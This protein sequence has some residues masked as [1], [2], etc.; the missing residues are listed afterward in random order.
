MRF[1]ISHGFFSRAAVF[2]FFAAFSCSLWAQTGAR[3]ADWY[4]GKPIRNVVFL[5]LKHVKQ[6]ELDGITEPYIGK[7]LTDAALAELLGRLYELEYFD[8]ISPETIPSG[9]GG[10]EAVLRFT[11]KERPHVSRVDFSGNSGL[12]TSELREVISTKTNSVYNQTKA[13]IDEQALVAKYIEKGFPDADVSV[14]TKPAGEN[15]VIV[16]F[17]VKEGEKVIIS[18]ITFEGNEHF[19]GKTL[20]NQLSLSPKG[21]LKDGAFQ[22]AKL[23]ADR[24]AV[25]QYYHDRGYIDA[26][27]IDV[28]RDVSRG[29]NGQQ[30]TLTFKI[31]EGRVY[32]FEGV[33]FEG[34]KIFS[35]DELAPLIRSRTGHTVNA[36]RVQADLMRVSDLYFENGYIYNTITPVERRDMERGTI[37]YTVKI[38]ERGRA[39]V[40]HI[41]VKGAKK[42]R[43]QVILREIPLEPGDIFSKS[44]VLDGYRNLLNL[45]YF[46]SVIPD[47]PPGSVD[48]LLDLIITV[49]EQ[50]TTDIQ[51]GLTFSGTSD[52][53]SFPVSLVLKWTDRN[54]LGY[55][56]IFGVE[57][58]ASPDLQN[59]SVNYT[60]RWLFGLPLSGGFDF[61]V[62]HARRIAAMDNQAPY[63]NGDEPYAYPD[64]FDSYN[65][66]VQANKIP[67]SQYLMEYQQWSISMGFSTGYRWRTPVGIYSMGGGL[68][69]GFKL[70]DYD[71]QLYR[72]FDRAL[73]ERESWTPATSFSFSTSL[74]QR[75]IFYDPS[76][77]YYISQRLGFYGLIPNAIEEE[78]YIRSDSKAEIFFTLWDVL[79]TEKWAFKGVLGLHT[80]FSFLLPQPG[81]KAPVIEQINMLSIDGMFVAR[82]WQDQRTVR[83]RG[84]WENWAELRIPIVPGILALDGFF[85]AAEVSVLPDELFS[86]DT[87][88]TWVD[89]MRFSFGGGLRFAIPQFPFRFLFAKRFKIVDGAV[90]WIPGAIGGDAKEGG[91]DFVLSFAISTY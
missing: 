81:Q 72:P 70:N 1:K 71:R 33:D 62:Q 76:R 80:G 86:S 13:R 75:D 48:G 77:G 14:S 22:E 25:A 5:G 79:V 78:Y 31:T 60:Q 69:V 74:D 26:A 58:N 43:D 36:Q 20:G 63:F 11:V 4:V 16:V 40:E 85:D 7:P 59:V 35:T 49:E 18:R 89:R 66:Y 87:A 28:T 61:T 15:N 91:V 10:N 45:Q 39:F 64:G 38:V 82:G 44:K 6:S 53:N 46:S 41:I 88:G 37:S 51:A 17:T 57:A 27:V 50:P 55:G 34:N 24:R 19:S 30:L 12:R 32:T 3:R 65:S 84:M 67:D 68:R 21:I 54:F 52:P 73:R 56:N 9:E 29:K 42:T 47:T 8:E 23:A 2:L 83:G 90:K